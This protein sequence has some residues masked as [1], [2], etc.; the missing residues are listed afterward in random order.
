MATTLQIRTLGSL[1][2]SIDDT[3]VT[4]F[5]SRKVQ[6]LL[7]YLACTGRTFPRE[8]LAELFWE[9]RTQSQALANLRVVLTSLRQTVEPFVEITRETVGL[10]DGADIWLDVSEFEAQINSS[11]SDLA[12]LSIALDLYQGDFLA[13]FF[14]DSSAFEEWATRE[15]ERLRLRAMEALDALITGCLAQVDYAKGIAAATRL[16]AMDPLREE[17]H[18]Q[19]MDLLW[20]SGARQSPRSIRQPVPPAGRG[21]RRDPA[22]RDRG[23]VRATPCWRIVS[24]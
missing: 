6:A 21:I 10:K 15:R 20:R 4:G 22:A 16:L 24:R 9:E 7:V 17:T 1:T 18:R 2:I 13:G 14:V 8:V 23:A 5:N 12:S 11:D 3:P 19:L